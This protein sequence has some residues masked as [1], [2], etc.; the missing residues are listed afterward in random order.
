MGNIYRNSIDHQISA[1]YVI[2]L[3][4]RVYNLSYMLFSCFKTHFRHLVME[5]LIQEQLLDWRKDP[6]RL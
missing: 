1:I 6:R 2:Y 3:A 4:I 5:R